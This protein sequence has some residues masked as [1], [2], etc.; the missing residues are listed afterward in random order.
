MNKMNEYRIIVETSVT[1]G[2]ENVT[3]DVL[4]VNAITPMDAHK[5]VHDNLNWSI[6]N[7]SEIYLNHNNELVYDAQN[8]FIE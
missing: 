7:I 3:E 5:Q 1:I 8:G 4:V 6:Q 2:Y